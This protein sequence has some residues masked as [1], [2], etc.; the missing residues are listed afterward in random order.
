MPHFGF[1][2]LL[3]PVFLE[4]LRIY[5]LVGTLR[6][7]RPALAALRTIAPFAAT[8]ASAA[9]AASA[10]ALLFAFGERRALSVLLVLRPAL[11]LRLLGARRPLVRPA[12]S[13]RA[14]ALRTLGL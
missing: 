2:L 7:L 1:A 8:A 6:V 9:P 12:F 10:P 5:G 13:L 14:F 11:L 4:L 3:Q